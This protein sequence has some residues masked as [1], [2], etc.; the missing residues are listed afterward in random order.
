MSHFL[1]RFKHEAQAV[2]AD[3]KLHP[4]WGFVVSGLRQGWHL[5]LG[6][7]EFQG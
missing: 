7:L 4:L 5:G 1:Q 3:P 2:L 6:G